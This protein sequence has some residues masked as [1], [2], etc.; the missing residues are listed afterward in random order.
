MRTL[1]LTALLLAFLPA[2]A[3]EAGFPEGIVQHAVHAADMAWKPCAA[4]LPPGCEMA[5]LEGNPAA[6]GLFTVRFML[7]DNFALPAHTHPRHERVT[8]LSGRISVAFGKDAKRADAAQ[9]GPGDFYI[10]A[11]GAVHSVWVDEAVEL[12][13]RG[14]GPWEANV[15]E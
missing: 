10:N 8:V 12:Q 14:F 2:H 1:S 7:A 3:E 9:F 6:S 11:R 15:V 13:I 5:V 4:N